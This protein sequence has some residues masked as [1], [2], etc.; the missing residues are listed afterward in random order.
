MSNH[1]EREDFRQLASELS[2]Q[3]AIFSS[4]P[5]DTV[6]WSDIAYVE[7]HGNG[8]QINATAIGFDRLRTPTEV[9]N[10][11]YDALCQLE[12]SVGGDT[13]GKI[14]SPPKDAKS[15]GKLTRMLRDDPLL[16]LCLCARRAEEDG[17]NTLWFES[18]IVD[19]YTLEPIARFDFH[20]SK[21]TLSDAIRHLGGELSERN[22]A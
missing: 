9:G 6:E 10:D 5:P 11:F 7:I 4:L 12:K 21:Q 16:A 18:R 17:K 22:G 13:G 14:T 20:G 15:Y 2:M 19:R 1:T 8:S 3:P